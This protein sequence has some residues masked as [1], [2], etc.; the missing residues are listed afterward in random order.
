MRWFRDLPVSI[1]VLLLL[2]LPM[3]GIGAEAYIGLDTKHEL[4]ARLKEADEVQL[5]AIR[6]LSLIETDCEVVRSS[7]LQAAVVAGDE[8]E[9][10]S[11]ASDVERQRTRTRTHLDALGEVAFDAESS[12]AR[13]ALRPAI[14]RYLAFAAESVAKL[15][16]KADAEDV[17]SDFQ[18]EYDELHGTSDALRTSIELGAHTSAEEGRKACDQAEKRLL[19]AGLCIALT[20]LGLG[21]LVARQITR[22][23]K[24]AVEVMRS[25]DVTR[26]AGIDRRDEIGQMA[27]AVVRTVGAA[28]EAAR[29]LERVVGDL[30]RKNLAVEEQ[31]RALEAA[32]RKTRAEA[33]RAEQAAQEAAR[34]ASMVEGAPT[35]MLFVDREHVV[36]Y[37]NP[38]S[39]KLFGDCAAFAAAGGSLVGTELARVCPDERYQL[40]LGECARGAP[41][42]ARLWLHG[43]WLDVLAAAIEGERGGLLVCFEDV[44]ELVAGE[45]REKERGRLEAEA[46]ENVRVK[47][48]A[49]LA[50][51][52]DAAR[53]DLTR[54]VDVVGDDAVGRVGEGLRTLLE[55]FRQSL[56]VLGE[57]AGTLM[58]SSATLK[59][60]SLR[61][62]REAQTTSSEAGRLAELSCE[63]SR[64]IENIATGTQALDERLQL[65]AA[66]SKDAASVARDAV[67]RAA[68]AGETVARLQQSSLEIGRILAVIQR[69][70]NQ[71]NLLALNAT[72]EAARA[73]EAGKGFAVVAGE[74]KVLAR[75]TASS[76]EDIER[77]ITSIQSET[78][79][80]IQ[81]IREVETVISR[82]DELQSAIAS[83]VD[84]QRVTSGAIS[85][86]ITQA[87]QGSAQMSSNM[88]GVASS[89][90]ETRDGAG[91]TLNSAE[92]VAALADEVRVLV[93]RF[94]V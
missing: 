34:V 47:V 50:V 19:L 72:I 65:V 26:L 69:I 89:T 84:E 39:V 49:L 78:N 64:N 67:Q 6:N 73:G 27:E 63:I 15:G 66:N 71:T 11:V 87:A 58:T 4:E 77:R 7:V 90:R 35:P 86:D 62:D 52:A 3:L 20:A 56:R 53:G 5:V 38:A 92:E 18:D 85:N 37:Q 2:V 45:A 59:T 30:Q 40:R 46:A 44:T 94:R 42:H 48:D 82:I 74:V 79:D 88:A 36:R 24:V 17:L 60:V 70:A 57:R 1:K 29:E 28:H 75:E 21:L 51:V 13:D 68:S 91:K 10:A 31:T 55:D 25:G 22:P 43:R 12:T 23:L 76:T 61:M 32:N 16:R 80:A 93:T 81:A 33:D 14:E 8:D 41:V 83:A 54:A 9:L